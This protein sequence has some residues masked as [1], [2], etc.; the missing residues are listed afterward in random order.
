MMRLMTEGF[1]SLPPFIGV[2][3]RGVK[4]N[5]SGTYTKGVRITWWAFSSCTTSTEVLESPMFLGPDGER[6]IFVIENAIGW[7]LS[8]YS[9]YDTEKEV[10]LPAGMTVEVQ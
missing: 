4:K 2:L 5:L 8:S 9:F 7:D 6:T 10:L 3:Y 1:E